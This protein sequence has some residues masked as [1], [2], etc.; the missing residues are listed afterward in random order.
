MHFFNTSNLTRSKIYTCDRDSAAIVDFQKDTLI[1]LMTLINNDSSLYL[2]S[3]YFLL[4]VSSVLSQLSIL[5]RLSVF[6]PLSL[7][8]LLFLL[9]VLSLCLY[10]L[11][12]SIV[13][14]V[15]IVKLRSRSDPGQVRVGSRLGA[16][17]VQDGSRSAPHKL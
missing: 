6:S 11:F 16:G 10:Y 7:L 5:C 17:W 13:S 14:I 9:S 15:S 4:S 2:L 8:S 12:F 3:L 1:I